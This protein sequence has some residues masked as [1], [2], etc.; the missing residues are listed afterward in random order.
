MR[1]KRTDSGEKS[2][3]VAIELCVVNAPSAPS[4]SGAHSQV[5]IPFVTKPLSRG[6]L[7]KP[8]L[9]YIITDGAPTPEPRDTLRRVIERARNEARD[10]GMRCPF[11]ITFAQVGNDADATEF[12]DEL[13]DDPSVGDIIDTVS[14]FD[15][16]AA[17]VLTKSC[18]C[19][20][21]TRINYMLKLMLGS[22][23]SRFDAMD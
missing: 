18:S 22:I 3:I 15:T 13:D 10:R 14:D 5:L 23:D 6:S 7:R 21:L 8:V 1:A 20:R 9:I 4:P 19:R 17:Q 12:L 2:A 16:E 11:G